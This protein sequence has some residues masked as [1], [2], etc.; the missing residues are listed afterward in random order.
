[1]LGWLSSILFGERAL[2][3]EFHVAVTLGASIGILSGV[4]LFPEKALLQA[5]ELREQKIG[6]RK[7][8]WREAPGKERDMAIKAI[9]T[10]S[11]RDDVLK[12]RK[13]VL[14]KFWAPWCGYCRALTP[15][16]ESIEKQY[17]NLLSVGRINFD[18]ET[19][20]ARR[21]NIHKMPTLLLFINGTVAGFLIDPSSEK[22]IDAF[23][24]KML[25]L[26]VGGL[27]GK[28]V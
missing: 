16:L 17:E 25:G 4:V 13:P 8:N 7:K 2:I 26:N 23:L 5:A 12:T 22:E 27:Y 28:H 14:V 18:T 1:M 24:K 9:T 19:A 10:D 3:T 15:A 6:S 11:F 21:Y 20:V